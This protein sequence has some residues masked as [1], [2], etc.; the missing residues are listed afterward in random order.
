IRSATGLELD[1]NLVVAVDEKDQIHAFS[2]TGSSV[3][4][5]AKFS[6]RILS[7]PTS[8]GPVLVLGDSKGLVHLVSRNDGAV[9]G[10]FSGDGTAI[11][12]QPVAAGRTALVQ[13]TG[14]ALIAVSIDCT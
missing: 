3:W 9:V 11:V 1:S 8:V 2:L 14:G 10:R 4:R 12:A 13:S 7:A 6:G 5:Q